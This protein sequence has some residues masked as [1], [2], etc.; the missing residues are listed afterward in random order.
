MVRD[1][2]VKIDWLGVLIWLILLP[3]GA[4]F[5][6]IQFWNFLSWVIK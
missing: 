6:I 4:V 1:S 3:L 5:C 2:K